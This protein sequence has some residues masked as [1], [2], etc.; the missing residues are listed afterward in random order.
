MSACW[1]LLQAGEP[2]DQRGDD[3]QYHCSHSRSGSPVTGGAS[4]LPLAP[5]DIRVEIGYHRS[6]IHVVSVRAGA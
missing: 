2:G 3:E 6:V 1:Y 5:P 4:R